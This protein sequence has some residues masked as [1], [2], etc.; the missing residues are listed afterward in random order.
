MW[1]WQGNSY[2]KDTQFTVS[3]G[4]RDVAVSPDG[5]RVAVTDV[6]GR[7]VLTDVADDRQQVL[8]NGNVSAHSNVAFTSDG[9][10]LLQADWQL[11]GLALWSVGDGQLLTVWQTG[12]H[13]APNFAGDM[14]VGTADDGTAV[15]NQPDGTA[16][17][18]RPEVGTVLSSLSGIAGELSGADV[19]RYLRGAAVPAACDE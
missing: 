16:L 6:D 2:K 8:D 9:A 15:T 5:S 10:M 14:E 7:V 13:T 1:H 4:V 11:G 17:L 18:W 12:A 3:A 19:A